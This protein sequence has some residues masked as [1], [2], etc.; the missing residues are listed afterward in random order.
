MKSSR[1]YIINSNEESQYLPTPKC[2]QVKDL[3]FRKVAKLEVV[4]FTSFR[5]TNLK[6]SLY[7]T[8]YLND[9]ADSY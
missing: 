4:L 3:F 2:Q 7:K 1:F 9:S 5:E 6:K 8:L